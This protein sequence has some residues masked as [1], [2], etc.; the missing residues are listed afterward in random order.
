MVRAFF[1]F[2]LFLPLWGQV[3]DAIENPM[4]EPDREY[5][6]LEVSYQLE[7]FPAE[8]RFNGTVTQRLKPLYQ[9]VSHLRFD[10]VG[11]EIQT[12]KVNGESCGFSPFQ[13]AP[14]AGIEVDTQRSFG[15]DD[16][17]TVEI[18][19]SGQ[20]PKMGLYFVK[21]SVNPESDQIWTQGEEME[22]RYWLPI[23]DYPN[24]RT[25]VESRISVPE[26]LTV[27][28]NGSLVSVSPTPNLP[29][30]Q[31]F[32]HRLDQSH[33][34]Y[35]IAFA[36]GEW[37]KVSENYSL[38]GRNQPLVLATYIPK[39]MPVER[40]QLAQS[41]LSEMLTFFNQKIG[42]LYPWPVY[43][44]VFVSHF[45]YGG[46][47]NTT[48]TINNDQ[49]LIDPVDRMDGYEDLR[50]LVAHELVH[51]WWGDLL[52]CRSWAHL[53]LNEGFAS[54][55][56][57]LYERQ[58]F[59]ES[60]FQLEVWKHQQATLQDDG[61]LVETDRAPE[62]NGE[63]HSE[64]RRGA[65]TLIML[66]HILG[67]DRFWRVLHSYANRHAYDL[68]DTN[69][70]A[71]A[72]KD[73]AGMNLD[74]FFDDWVYQ[75]GAPEVAVSYSFQDGQ[76]S[77]TVHQAG[78]ENH[79][80]FRFPLEV[81]CQTQAGLQ[82]Q[83][84]WVNRN[85]ATFTWP[86]DSEPRWLDL[87][88][89]GFLLANLDLQ[90]SHAAWLALARESSN[91]AKRIHAMDKACELDLAATATSLTWLIEN[92]R[93][94]LVQ[95]HAI[96]NSKSLPGADKVKNLWVQSLEHAQVEVRA[97]ALN[98][99][100]G[101]KLNK[102]AK[103]LLSQLKSTDASSNN[104]FLALA[105]LACDDPKIYHDEIMARFEPDE[106]DW[107]HASALI[108]TVL[109]VYPDEG[110]ERCWAKTDTRSWN[111]L[112]VNHIRI[113]LSSNPELG[114]NLLQRY[115]EAWT[116]TND[117]RGVF[118]GQM[119]RYA[120]SEEANALLRQWVQNHPDHRGAQTLQPMLENV[121]GTTDSG[122][123]GHSAPTQ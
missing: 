45:P 62:N 92:D 111:F 88:P 119:L 81:Q 9:S 60:H 99:L 13:Q 64:Y 2:S 93:E 101:E 67:E 103:K 82:H 1:L 33:V 27:I 4:F 17:I 79:P 61:P 98:A 46:M 29:G 85:Q 106:M 31:T 6:L 68:V 3:F 42:V 122:G 63:Y 90:Q 108:R 25:L 107:D 78:P 66:H 121:P 112:L 21:S 100:F 94:P 7:L 16:L 115:L 10:Q 51:H 23:Y 102:K 32:H 118:L 89:R 41:E 57:L 71:N 43:N 113:L 39:G 76:L 116:Q 73:F 114:I 24:D 34:T 86:L 72:I 14:R 104:R 55:F 49:E 97:S 91:P 22:N 11:L 8:K 74:W 56:E 117:L 58:Q 15:P 50:D 110:F 30:Y 105:V 96:Q 54:Y 26:P 47:E 70:F 123:A 19:Y 5:D 65:A 120:P 36:A 84:F 95:A 44:Q 69:D 53:W 38:P 28:A 40:A 12:V 35:L 52:T 109:Q 87:D 20:D 77:L 80:V 48:V 75:A 83:T 18:T 59:G 37:E